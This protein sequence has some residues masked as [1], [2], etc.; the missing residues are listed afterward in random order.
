MSGEDNKAIIRRYYDE[1]W[2]GA[3]LAVVDELVAAT[4][5]PGGP[6]AEKS[7]IAGAHAAF[8]EFR[9]TLDDLLAAERDSVVV[10]W[11]ARGT[12][13]GKFRGIAPTGKQA[14]WSGISIYR[15]AAGKVVAGWSKSDQLVLLQQLGATIS[16]PGQPSGARG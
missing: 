14:T 11:T 9:I 10:R 2:N 4:Y 5:Q 16:T 6:E 7:L 1:A 12:H 15:L 8:A 13:G 3:D